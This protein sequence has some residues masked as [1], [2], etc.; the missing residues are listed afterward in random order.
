MTYRLNVKKVLL[1]FVANTTK[2]ILFAIAIAERKLKIENM[3]ITNAICVAD[4]F[5]KPVRAFLLTPLLT[6]IA[7]D[8]KIMTFLKNN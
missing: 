5:I 4:G 2:P 1:L 8:A 3:R 6:F 7:R